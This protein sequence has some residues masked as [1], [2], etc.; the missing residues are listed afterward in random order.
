MGG[1]QALW[2]VPSC[3]QVGAPNKGD[4]PRAPSSTQAWNGDARGP[5]LP[6][7]P[8]LDRT[9]RCAPGG[10]RA[11]P[12]PQPRRPGLCLAHSQSQ[13]LQRPGSGARGSS[14]NWLGGLKQNRALNSYSSYLQGKNGERGDT[15]FPLPSSSRL[16]PWEAEKTALVG[17]GRRVKV[18]F[19]PVTHASVVFLFPTPIADLRGSPRSG[20]SPSTKP[21]TTR[22]PGAERAPGTGRRP[23]LS[24]GWGLSAAAPP[25]AAGGMKAE[26]GA[27]VVLRGGLRRKG[28]RRGE[29]ASAGTLGR[30][31]ETEGHRETLSNKQSK[32]PL[33][34]FFFPFSFLPFFFFFP[35]RLSSLSPICKA[36]TTPRA[37]GLEPRLQ[38]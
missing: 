22:G 10:R 19:L 4:R 7:Q 30:R 37:R 24:L 32:L 25:V 5:G 31:S 3:A 27:R 20:V 18:P 2:P 16:F 8:G 1:S 33:C 34:L 9:R 28:E 21:R 6:L 11:G 36:G 38:M 17:G 35:F 29:K 23:P 13:P 14:G 15:L 12:P 26:R